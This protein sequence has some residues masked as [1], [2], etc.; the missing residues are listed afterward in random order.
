MH[1]HICIYLYVCTVCMYIYIA[2]T[3]N[4]ILLASC[5]SNNPNVTL[6]MLQF[7]LEEAHVLLPDD[8]T[9]L[10]CRWFPGDIIRKWWI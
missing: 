2:Y 9:E 4:D 3:N 8:A 5:Q 7:R 1:I 10:H 6:L